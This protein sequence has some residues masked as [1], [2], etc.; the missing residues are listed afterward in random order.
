M[1]AMLGILRFV[2][3][4]A[5]FALAAST[6]AQTF[7][8]ET[9]PIGARPPG[10]AVPV[11]GSEF[12]IE[13]TDAAGGERCARLHR[14]AGAA[15]VRNAMRSFD[16]AAHRGELLTLRAK[17]RV[18]K[19]GRAQLWLRVDRPGQQ[20]GFFDNMQ[21]RPVTST[22]WQ[23]VEITGTVAAD[24][25]RF[26]FGVLLMAGDDL[27]IDDVR[28]GFT[29]AGAGSTPLPPAPLSARGLDN[30]AAFA[31]LCGYV[32]YFHPSDAAAT[33][34]WERFVIDGMRDVENST[35]AAAL[36]TDLQRRFAAIA[37]TLRVAV[38]ATAPDDLALPPPEGDVA[39]L[40]CVAWVHDGVGL[41]DESIYKSK[42]VFRR[43]SA[44]GDL[45]DPS[46]AL[47]LDLDGGV[48]CLLPVTL[49]AAGGATLPNS[50]APELPPRPQHGA[51]DRATRL[52]AVALAWNVFEHFYPYF[53]VV[54]G[55]WH[56]SLRTALT[57]AATDVDERA[58][59]MTLQRLVADL[60]DGHGNVSW[61]MDDRVAAPPLAVGWIEDRLV[62]T[63]VD[64]ALHE[65]VAVGDV[66]LELDGSP[67]TEVFRSAVALHSGA[68]EGWRRH[69]AENSVLL[70]APG[71][72]L[73]LTLQRD[74]GAA[75]EVTVS[76]TPGASPLPPRPEPIG[77]L[78]PGIW[79]LDVDRATDATLQAALPQL[80]EA[81]AIVVDFRG[82]PRGMSPQR[83]F[84]HFL[85]ETAHSA[86]WCVPHVL[87]PDRTDLQCPEVGRWTLRP[88]RPHLDA[89][90]VFVTHAGAISYAESCL[91]IVEHYHLGEIV[92]ER[93]AGTNGN[94]NPFWL[95]GKFN[96][97]WTGMR[98][99]KHDGSQHH[100][101]GIAPT[102]P[103]SRTVAGV[104]AGRDELLDRAVK[105]AVE[106]ARDD[107]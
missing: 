84:G 56:A 59:L 7:D 99:L 10:W 68:T 31:R 107:K 66:I 102:V 35:N 105:K 38:T 54:G 49:Y 97:S 1:A 11:P 47:R 44:R 69:R 78:E 79:Y 70:G 6:P 75:V 53:D 39:Q 28:V 72:D 9:D 98:V 60:H 37:P 82:Y 40:R 85:T 86:R 61:M 93:T 29:A 51:T 41:S 77:E 33:L 87:L 42:R 18:G 62:V 91:G 52:A 92:G 36:A 100:G 83:L 24:A 101:V 64:A 3:G 50:T 4:A 95:P 22:S 48:T 88:L 55:D 65:R 15:P 46:R 16:V 27:W 30:V 19:G 21:D 73:R 106:L 8:F 5:L 23:E 34:D 74:G 13:D 57:T 96:V 80:Q 58:F 32:R 17:L 67:A 89:R 81:K 76:R 94:V 25:E 63:A 71:S 14:G 45:P 104:R 26:A 103:V 20:M 2:P 90:L 12:T 43:L